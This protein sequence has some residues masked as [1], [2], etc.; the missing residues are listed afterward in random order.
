MLP[1]QPIL[2]E[3]FQGSETDLLSAMYAAVM[4]YAALELP[5]DEFKIERSDRI[6]VEEMA[7]SPTMLRLLQCLIRI[8]RPKRIL[9]IGAFLGISAMYMAK[10][11]DEDGKLVSIE[12]FDHF[13]EIARRNFEANGLSEKI[14]LING[15]AFEVLRTFPVDERFDLIFLDGNKERY[16]DYFSI[17]DPLLLSG[18]LF[19]TDDVF[20]HGDALNSSPKTEKGAGVRRFLELTTTYK[21]YHRVILPV[22]N[23]FMLMLK[24]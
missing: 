6:S 5:T 17:L 23:G 22:A 2:S 14:Q 11:L 16:D 15:D 10:A 18:G 8:R 24:H 4:N 9:E 12:K 3:L 19:I 13:A 7:S 21:N 1:T 20:F